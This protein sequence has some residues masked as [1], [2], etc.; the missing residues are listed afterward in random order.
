MKKI[1]RTLLIVM[2]FSHFYSFNIRAL[3]SHPRSFAHIADSFL[4]FLLSLESHKQINTCAERGETLNSLFEKLKR[5]LWGKVSAYHFISCDHN[6]IHEKDLLICINSLIIKIHGRT[7]DPLPENRGAKV[8]FDSLKNAV[9]GTVLVLLERKN[10]EGENLPVPSG[11]NLLNACSSYY[12]PS[13]LEMR[14]K[15]RY[16][17]NFILRSDTSYDDFLERVSKALSKS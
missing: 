1:S 15:N 11:Y 8:S 5:D 17:E 13:A 9:L 2:V 16:I 14:A 10:Q 3:E 4:N 7:E 6:E 12:S